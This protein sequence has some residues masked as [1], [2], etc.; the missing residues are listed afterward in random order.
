VSTSSVIVMPTCHRPE[1][2]ALSLESVRVSLNTPRDVRIYIDCCSDERAAEIEYVRNAYLPMARLYRSGEHVIAPSGCFNILRALK[3]G[4]ESGAE[5]VFLV[6]EDVRVFVNY[7]DR[8][9]EAH[10]QPPP[11]FATCGRLQKFGDGC[12]TNPGA[13]FRRC[14][15]ASVVPHINED[16]FANRRE[17]MDLCFGS[18]DE[19]SDLDDGLIRRVIRSQEGLVRTLDPPAVAHQGFKYYN[20]LSY[21]SV[22]GSIQERIQRL[23]ILL[24]RISP[25]DRYTRDFEPFEVTNG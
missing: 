12:Y 9:I 19:A 8:S 4:Y 5:Y 20:V 7:F 14:S 25:I 23:R 24:D 18:M 16:F 15:L 1:F 10:L 21:L 13:C 2:L 17:Y 3:E 6:E 22:E 11:V